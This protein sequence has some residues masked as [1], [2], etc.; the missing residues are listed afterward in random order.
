MA[1]KQITN[2]K[3]PKGAKGDTGDV[4]LQGERGLPGVNAVENDA[5]VATY[6]RAL[7]SETGQAM[8]ARIQSVLYPDDSM[9]GFADWAAL[10][11]ADELPLGPLAAWGD[12]SGNGYDLTNTMP[13]LPQVV[14]WVNGRKAV[15]F[16]ASPLAIG[17]ITS[18]PAPFTIV[19]I[20]DAPN[21]PGW[22]VGSA[23]VRL[24]RSSG[25][26]TPPGEYRVSVPLAPYTLST[27]VQ[28]SSP[29]VFI[30]TVDGL[31]SRLL[32]GNHDTV[33]ELGTASIEDIKL[34]GYTLPANDLIDGHIAA[35]GLVAGR[36]SPQQVAS[37]RDWCNV[38]YGVL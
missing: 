6:M 35:F 23:G 29:H 13:T 1:W 3:G 38:K 16:N 32:F 5:A 15:K 14:T 12:S 20:G 31:G 28:D 19:V 7:D 27:G 10:Y 18:I 25:S 22:L 30:A 21:Y 33:G 34:G 2:I 24:N 9:G 26:T 36:L 11:V 17:A 4:G 37:I 8:D